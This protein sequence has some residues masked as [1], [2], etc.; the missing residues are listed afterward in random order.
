VGDVARNV[1]YLLE[2]EEIADVFEGSEGNVP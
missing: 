1:L 2:R